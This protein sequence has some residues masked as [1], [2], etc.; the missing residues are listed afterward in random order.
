MA[1][2]A[3]KPGPLPLRRAGTGWAEVKELF[4]S[5]SARKFA[6]IW[7]MSETVAEVARKVSRSC[8]LT[9][10]NLNDQRSVTTILGSQHVIQ[11]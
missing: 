7:Q 2:L 6:W 9:T 4:Q 3:P 11:R 1:I 5:V 8:S 10:G